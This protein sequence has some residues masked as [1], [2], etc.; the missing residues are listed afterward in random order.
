MKTY[1]K[2]LDLPSLPKHLNETLRSQLDLIYKHFSDTAH[3]SY[4]GFSGYKNSLNYIDEHEHLSRFGEPGKVTFYQLGQKLSNRD[5]WK[6]IAIQPQWFKD[7]IKGVLF[8]T[9]GPGTHVPPHIDDSK[10]RKYGII[11]LLDAGGD[12]VITRWYDKKKDLKHLPVDEGKLITYDSLDCVYE[13]KLEIHKWY[14]GDYSE[15]HSIENLTR[16]RT[17]IGIVIKS[18]A[19]INL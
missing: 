14:L 7:C 18:D 17:A 19:D 3:M 12:N 10:A 2:Q 8:Q 6:F 13:H 5:L 15:I 11:Y 9:I 16:M 1:L 4:G